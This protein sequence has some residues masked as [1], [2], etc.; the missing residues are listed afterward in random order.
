M[1][2]KLRDELIAPGRLFSYVEKPLIGSR[3]AETYPAAASAS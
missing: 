2:D 3:L 1:I